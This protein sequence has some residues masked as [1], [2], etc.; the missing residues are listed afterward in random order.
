MLKIVDIS[1][2]NTVTDWT[3]LKANA[4]A[5]LI[6]CGQGTMED[7]KFRTNLAGAQKAGLRVGIWWFYH[8]DMAAQ[9]QI[10]KFVSIYNSLTVKPLWIS[11]DV[12]ESA[13]VDDQGTRHVVLPPSIETYSA[14]LAQWLATVED[15][16]GVRPAI[17]TRASWWDQ[18]VKPGQWGKYPLWVANYGVAKPLLPRDWAGKLWLFWQYGTTTTPGILT[19]VD[20]DWFDGTEADLDKVFGIKMPVVPPAPLPPASVYADEL[21]TMASRLA[22]IAGKI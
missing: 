12:E 1:L 16:T 8:P 4:A 6:K 20:S 15:A 19:P 10:D 18:W 2:Y 7:P 13:W 5:V 21:R 9:L 22:E 3:L 14:W 17:Y 11:L